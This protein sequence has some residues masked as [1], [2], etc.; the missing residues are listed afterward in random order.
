M[1]EKK[2]IP[3][4]LEDLKFLI[5]R[6]G[7]IVTRIYSYF[8]FEQSR[9]KRDFILMNRKSRQQAKTSIERVTLNY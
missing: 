1:L 9:Y 6:V 7:W 3:I 5:Q 4:Y 2:I 8:T